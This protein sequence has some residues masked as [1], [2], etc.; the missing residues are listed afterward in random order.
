LLDFGCPDPVL[1]EVINT[2]GRPRAF[3]WH[4]GGRTST[5]KF[6][7]MLL[8][9]AGQRISAAAAFTIYDRIASLAAGVPT[10]AAIAALGPERLRRC[11]LSAARA[12]YAVALAEAERPVGRPAHKTR[13]GQRPRDARIAAGSIGAATP[14]GAPG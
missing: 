4:D 2:Y 13:A 12:G 8:H 1:A 6:A 5:S 9:V 11:G 3:E 7:A 10:A 14:G